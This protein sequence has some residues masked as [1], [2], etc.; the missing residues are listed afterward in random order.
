MIAARVF[1]GAD[2]DGQY[3]PRV[4][5][6]LVVV[7]SWGHQGI[8]SLRPA[9]AGSLATV[10]A[11]GSLTWRWLYDTGPSSLT[12]ARDQIDGFA[13]KS[14]FDASAHLVGTTSTGD[15]RR[16]FGGILDGLARDGC[17]LGAATESS[18]GGWSLNRDCVDDHTLED[19]SR[20]PAPGGV[21]AESEVRSAEAATAG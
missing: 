5:A 17:E 11:D 2:G 9:A 18:E 19:P 7:G 8:V 4:G 15:E 1:C 20:R 14:L 6:R 16:E 10:E 13:A 21:A 12:R 3:A